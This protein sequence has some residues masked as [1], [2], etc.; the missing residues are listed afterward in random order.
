MDAR[1]I[2][3][4][5]QRVGSAGKAWQQREHKS[6][7]EAHTRVP[8][9]YV[10]ADGTGAPMRPEELEGRD[11]KQADGTARTRQAYLG[12]VFTQHKVDEKGRPVRDWASTTNI[13]SMENNGAFGPMLRA[14]ALPGALP[15][16]PS[17]CFS[18]TEP[19]G[20]RTWTCS[21]SKTPSQSW[22]SIMP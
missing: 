19:L 18:L 3:R 11:G 4:L 20:W 17:W 6:G 8:I 22:I 12:C 9:M 2:Q 13:L 10:S 16:P 15:M 7:R 1:Q 21:T 14:E 5:V